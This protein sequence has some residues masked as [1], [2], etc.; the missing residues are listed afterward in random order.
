MHNVLSKA[1][2]RHCRSEAKET[3]G[4]PETQLVPDYVLGQICAMCSGSNPRRRCTK[5]TGAINF[6]SSFGQSQA[7][8]PLLAASCLALKPYESHEP[9]SLVCHSRL[10]VIRLVCFK[11]APSGVHTRGLKPAAGVH[12]VF[13]RALEDRVID[14]SDDNTRSFLL[15]RSPAVSD[16]ESSRDPDIIIDASC[17]LLM[18]AR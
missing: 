13:P 9:S 6:T 3:C 2:R 1:C 10:A 8:G 14:T 12:R 15:L 7:V 18:F 16:V 4:R 5:T 17:R 11:V